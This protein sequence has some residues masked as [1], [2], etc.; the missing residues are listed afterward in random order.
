MCW[1]TEGQIRIGTGMR[2]E[3]FGCLRKRA[4]DREVKDRRSQVLQIAGTSIRQHRGGAQGIADNS[5]PV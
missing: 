1:L 4:I 3:S 5:I 2:G